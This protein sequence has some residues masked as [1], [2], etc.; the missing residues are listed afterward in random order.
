MSTTENPAPEQ[1][2]APAPAEEPKR[3]YKVRP[4][5]LYRCGKYRSED[6]KESEYDLRVHIMEYLKHVGMDHV[7]YGNKRYQL[8][9]TVSLINPE[10]IDEEEQP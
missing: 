1:P 10:I 2:T 9:V 7:F 3:N 5:R 6:K 8:L 4:C